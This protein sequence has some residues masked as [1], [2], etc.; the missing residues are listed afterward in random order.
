M[1]LDDL[2]TMT[3][4]TQTLDYKERANYLFSRHYTV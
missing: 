1:I 4:F 2:F 3:F